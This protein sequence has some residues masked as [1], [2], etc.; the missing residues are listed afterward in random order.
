MTIP[1]R[2]VRFTGAFLRDLAILAIVFVAAASWG[3]GGLMRGMHL[4]QL[5]EGGLET[6]G[7]VT[8]VVREEQRDGLHYKIRYEFA[9]GGLTHRGTFDTPR[10]RYA[11]RYSRGD[12]TSVTY[13]AEDP[14]FS[15]P[16][17]KREIDDSFVDWSV[18][19][20]LATSEL[21][22][23]IAVLLIGGFVAF[24]MRQRHLL[25]HCNIIG[26]E[27]VA[28][29]PIC[30]YRFL[31]PSGDTHERERTWLRKGLSIAP[32]QRVDVCWMPGQPH[33][34]RLLVDVP[35]VRIDE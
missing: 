26:G 32:G 17:A 1:R 34:S 2:H 25:M 27:V 31:T 33:R 7:S 9:A 4:R 29:D 28:S 18:G 22:S 23:G 16:R 20:R 15:V 35:Y 12:Q 14:S 11:E 3:I 10:L 24:A 5:R 8:D 6:T 19:S 13:L 30:R 21:L